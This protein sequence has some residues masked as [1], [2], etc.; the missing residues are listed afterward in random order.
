MADETEIFRRWLPANEEKY[1]RYEFDVHVGG[2]AHPHVD[3]NDPVATGYKRL[4]Q[5]RI[6]VLAYKGNEITIIEV[7][8]WANQTA[9]GNL[10]AYRLLYI[11]DFKPAVDIKLALITNNIRP[12]D[13]Y[14]FHASGVDVYVV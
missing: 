6:D 11:A 12:D 3:L 2:G 5:K 7:R 14:I 9:L 8:P 10:M 4:T 13:A 1:D